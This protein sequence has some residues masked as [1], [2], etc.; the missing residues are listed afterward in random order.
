MQADAC[1]HTWIGGPDGA[2]VVVVVV[3]VVVV[4][5]VVVFGGFFGWGGGGRNTPVTASSAVHKGCLGYQQASTLQDGRVHARVGCLIRGLSHRDAY[6]WVR[7]SL[8]RSRDMSGLRPLAL[9][10]RRLLWVLA[11]RFMRHIVGA[12]GSKETF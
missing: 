11:A 2:N 10:M 5:V 7:E 3:I 1:R 12:Q 6:S 8:V 9:R 4:V